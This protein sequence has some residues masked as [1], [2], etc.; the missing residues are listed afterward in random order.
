MSG[1]A[2]GYGHAGELS[3]A[4]LRRAAETVSQVASGRSGSWAE[5]PRP[6]NAR[7]YSPES[8]FGGSDFAARTA[9]LADI[10]AYARA[11]D[12]RVSQVMASITGEWQAVQIVRPDGRRVADL[13]PLVRLN[14]SVVVQQNGRRET[15][16]FGTGGRFGY[17]RV[18]GPDIW[19][20]AADEAVRQ[21]LLNLDSRAAPAGEM[22]VVTGSRLA[23]HLAA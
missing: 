2:A 10:D 17:D 8:P 3:E 9:V 6:T 7:L 23:R 5:P 12:A 19:R 20:A 4:A 14:V 1:E 13:R 15:G 22:P 21:A 18:I 16:S 11:K